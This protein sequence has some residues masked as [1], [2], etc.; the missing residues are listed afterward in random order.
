VKLFNK[1]AIIGVGLIGGSLALAI[2]RKR[3]ANTL[4]G[5]SRQR[6]TLIL[7]RKLRAVDVASQD[8]NII[9]DADLIILATPVHTIL[10][11]AKN[12]SR[13]VKPGAIVSDVG[14][15]KQEIVRHLSKLFPNYVGS[16]P[17]TGSEKRGVINADARMFNGS[18]C[19]L[20]PTVSTDKQSVI[21]ISRL[22]NLLGARVVHLKPSLHD[23]VL[24]FV[25]HMPHLVAFSLVGSVP[26]KYLRFAT[27][28]FKDTTRIA[29]SDAALWK[30]IFISNR[31]SLLKA[32]GTFK[33]RLSEIESAISKKDAKG[34]EGILRKAK[35]TR[36]SLK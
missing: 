1:V 26:K 12:I 6:K 7:A 15:T 5:I 19:I 21:K 18:L 2:K 16:H 36:D 14:S 32:L 30:D 28:G 23:S 3:L 13:L 11:I 17:L 27:S 29:S 9:K 34:L 33:H 25:S 4:I 10:K 35:K 22:W 20:T 31:K 8:L 24:S